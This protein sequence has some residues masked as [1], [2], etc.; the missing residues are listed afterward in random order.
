[1]APQHIVMSLFE[2]PYLIEAPHQK[3][4]QIGTKYQHPH[5]IEAPQ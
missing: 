3:G 4:L 5:K 1:M 2:A